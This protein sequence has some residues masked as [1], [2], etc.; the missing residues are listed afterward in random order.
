M[1]NDHIYL[2]LKKYSDG[3]CSDEERVLIENWYNRFNEDQQRLHISEDVFSG[4]QMRVGSKLGIQNRNKTIVLGKRIAIAASLIITFALGTYLYTLKKIDVSV[5]KVSNIS[6]GSDKATLRLAD[7]SEIDL[8]KTLSANIADEENVVIGKHKVG[9]LVMTPKPNNVTSEVAQNS[10]VVPRGGKYKLVLNDGTSV[11]LNS[12]SSLRFPTSFSGRNREVELI[13]EAYFE[14]AK[15]SSRPFIVKT[16]VQRIEVLGTHFNVNAYDD[17]EFTQTT[18]LEGRVK[19][20]N[21]A[22]LLPGQAGKSEGNHIK[23]QEADLDKAIAWKDGLFVFDGNSL[24]SIMRQ[25]GRWYNVDV[26]FKAEELKDVTFS[27]TVSRSV[28]LQT[29]LKRLRLTKEV[30]FDLKG[31]NIFVKHYN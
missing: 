13:G 17:E 29:I 26:Q 10:L 27:G 6:P 7:G 8:S 25:V 19:I 23:V 1:E 31:N 24:S 4:V 20:N 30:D 22:V 21:T 3:E 12:S 15:D 5:A 11:W 28:S 16:L 18:L 9:E 2:L 14:V